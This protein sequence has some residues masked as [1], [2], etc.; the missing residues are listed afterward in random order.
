MYSRV[1]SRDV[2]G[3]VPAGR[4]LFVGDHRADASCNLAATLKGFGF[5]VLFFE[6][7]DCVRVMLNSPLSPTSTPRNRS[8]LLVDLDYCYVR[9][10]L[11]LA[12]HK[13]MAIREFVPNVST[14]MVSRNFSGSDTTA[15]FLSIA[16]ARVKLPVSTTFLADVLA[17]AFSNNEE[18]QKR[19]SDPLF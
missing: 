14:I 17:S 1:S 10:G 18:W 11:E 15:K 7:I 13:T 5:E 12:V 8:I 19:V 3:V 4:V 6:S 16:D 2:D 9:D